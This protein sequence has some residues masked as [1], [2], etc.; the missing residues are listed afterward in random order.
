M[1]SAHRRYEAVRRA[2]SILA[3]ADNSAAMLYR[4]LRLRSIA[5][6]DAAF[7]VAYV[8][9]KGLIREREQLYRQIAKLANEKLYGPARILAALCEKGYRAADIRACIDGLV[10]QGELDFNEIRRTLYEKKKPQDEAVRQKLA[11]KHGFDR[12]DFD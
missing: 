6:E 12:T 7:A 1:R 10:A 8:Q 2:L 9:K 3:A 11:F 4:K 5:R